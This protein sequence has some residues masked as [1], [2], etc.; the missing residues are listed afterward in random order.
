M[1][2]HNMYFNY[3]NETNNFLHEISKIC[4]KAIYLCICNA[5]IHLKKVILQHYRHK[6]RPPH[7]RAV[8]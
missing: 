2:M 4:N 1:I 8:F 7:Y 5:L 3:C 6:K